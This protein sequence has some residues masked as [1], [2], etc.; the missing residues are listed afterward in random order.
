MVMSDAGP[1]SAVNNVTLTLSDA[2]AASLGTGTIVSGTYKPTNIGAGDTFAS[3]AP[4]GPYGTNL[5]AFNGTVGQRDVV[6]VC[7]G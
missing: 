2:A 3:P 4:A 7:G 6:V 5:A 1:N